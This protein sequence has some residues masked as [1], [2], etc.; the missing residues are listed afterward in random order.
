MWKNT[1][2][3]QATLSIFFKKIDSKEIMYR[4]YKDKLQSCSLNQP[5]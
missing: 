4:I 2:I 5:E 3:Y 1:K